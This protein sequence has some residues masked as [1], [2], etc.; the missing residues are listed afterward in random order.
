MEERANFISDP[1]AAEA[2]LGHNY[3]KQAA[4]GQSLGLSRKRASS[5]HINDRRF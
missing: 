3:C 2:L 5:E 4:V 1:N